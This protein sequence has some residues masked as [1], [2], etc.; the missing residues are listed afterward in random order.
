MPTPSQDRKAILLYA[1]IMVATGLVMF[2]GFLLGHLPVGADNSLLYAPFFSL[3]WDGGPPL[4]TPYSLSG[5]PLVD[6]LQAALLYPL[7]WPFFF[8]GDW[9]NYFGL[10]NFLHY[11]VALSGAAV[12]LRALGSSRLAALAGAIVFAC[13]SHM[14]GHLINQTLS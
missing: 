10:F 7:R 13:G 12:L 1:A 4:W 3:H 8:T 6:N 2:G 9:R 11:M 5:V 14:T